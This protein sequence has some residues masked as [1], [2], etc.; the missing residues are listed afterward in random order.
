V[1]GMLS[2]AAG[3][4]VSLIPF[5]RTFRNRS[6]RSG[7]G[8]M[9]AAGTGWLVVAVLYDAALQTRTTHSHTPV[10]WCGYYWPAS[11]RRY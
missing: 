2:Y 9:L 1:V 3:V 5:V 10:C 7:A 11:L 4:A 8:W 6:P